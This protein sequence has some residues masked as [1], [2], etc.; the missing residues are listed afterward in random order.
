MLARLV[1]L[2]LLTEFAISAVIREG[3]YCYRAVRK[4][5]MSIS[6]YFFIFKREESEMKADNVPEIS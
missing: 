1:I 2:F 4:Q 5:I 6:L 3:M